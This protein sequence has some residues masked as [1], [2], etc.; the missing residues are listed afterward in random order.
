MRTKIVKLLLHWLI[1]NGGRLPAQVIVN[2]AWVQAV[3]EFLKQ[4]D[5]A[6]LVRGDPALD[7]D[8]VRLVA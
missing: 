7:D 4:L 8:D 2:A 5:V 3:R 6:V 1:H